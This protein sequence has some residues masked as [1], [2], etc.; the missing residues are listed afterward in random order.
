MSSVPYRNIGFRNGTYVIKP[1]GSPK[2]I[3]V[4]CQID[5]TP[6]STDAIGWTVIQKRTTGREDFN[7]TYEQ[8]RYGFGDPKQDYW[9]G[10][11][12]IHMLTRQSDCLL[13]IDAWDIYGDYYYAEYG[14]FKVASPE[15]GFRLDIGHH[16]G[17]LTDSLQTHNG[18]RFSAFDQDSD[19]SSTHCARYYASGWWFSNCQK[20]N[21]NG[22]FPLG[23]I[24]FSNS[25]NDWLQLHKTMMKVRPIK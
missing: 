20:A 18:M 16:S 23:V 12:F 5:T 22:I 1:K 2:A 10:N 21:L 8:Y 7:R 17:N 19:A 24:W 6:T 15:E 14:T 9:L 4:Y 3:Q 13:R 11:E 25:A